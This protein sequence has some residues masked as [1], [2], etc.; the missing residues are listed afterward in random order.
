MRINHRNS[1]KNRV[2]VGP[3]IF[4]AL[5]AISVLADPV[6]S[7]E[8]GGNMNNQRLGKIIKRLDTRATGQPGHWQLSIEGVKLLV[9]TDEQANRMRIISPI[10]S[11]QVLSS[12]RLFRLMQANFDSALDARYSIAKSVL[13]STFIHP[14]N[15][16]SGREF[17]SGVG[18]VVN[19]SQ[20]YGV[21][22]TSGA[23]VFRGG[24]SEALQ[25]G[26][27]IDRLMEKGL[28]L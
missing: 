14:L 19:L 6:L 3:V 26:R 8:S 24:D 22:F 16:L 27:L 18:Q 7:K 15:S 21:S 10:T 25:K 1:G 4:S 17:I 12:K 5:L 13:W 28:V 23:L 11:A 2:I 20:T 9:I